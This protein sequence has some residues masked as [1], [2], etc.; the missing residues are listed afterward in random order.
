MRRCRELAWQPALSAARTR[1]REREVTAKGGGERAEVS[2]RASVLAGMGK[3]D[4]FF[5]VGLSSFL[6]SLG[7]A[8]T[9][10]A[11]LPRSDDA[12]GGREGGRG[13]RC[14]QAENDGN[15]RPTENRASERAWDDERC[16]SLS[17]RKW[18][19]G[20]A[21]GRTDDLTGEEYA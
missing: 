5:P 10:A 14:K 11:S 19:G 8:A 13:P 3:L 18:S 6:L 15:N 7:Y 9:P 16:V 2:E 17:Q 4:G 21:G 20:R 12:E 1:R